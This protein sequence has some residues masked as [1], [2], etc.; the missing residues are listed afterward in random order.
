[1]LAKGYAKSINLNHV[2]KWEIIG[3]DPNCDFAGSHH[4]A[5][6]GLCWRHA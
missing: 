4:R 2:A 6:S 5:A 1:M 3:E